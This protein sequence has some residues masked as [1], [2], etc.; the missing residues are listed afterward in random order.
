M[1]E[2][3]VRID[4]W[5]WACRFYKTRS[6]A[7]Q[8]IDGGKVRVNGGRTKPSREVRIGDE[9]RLKTGWDEK[10][11]VVRALSD[12]R[13]GAPEAQQL[14]EETQESI[15]ERED[16]AAQRKVSRGAFLVSDARPTKKQRRQIHQFKRR[17][18][19]DDAGH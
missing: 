6:L 3:T 14:Y 10:T 9:V 19:E 13:R 16:R 12:Q 7:K 4:K 17:S 18:L 5:L 11:V 1:T 8:E 2:Q 15:K